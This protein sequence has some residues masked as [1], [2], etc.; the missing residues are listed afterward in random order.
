MTIE[1]TYTVISVDQETNN[2]VVEYAAIGYSSQT[3]NV[4]LP[5]LN[6]ETLDDVISMYSPYSEWS[7]PQAVTYAPE[8]GATGT[9][10]TSAVIALSTEIMRFDA[11]VTE[12]DP[13]FF[14]L[15]RGEATFQQWQN[16]VDEIKA[17]YPN[18]ET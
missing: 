11:Y 14:K 6:V 4:R 7:T 15:Q 8:I 2:M 3:V 1:Y 9:L 16:K 13:I 17:R 12:S 10:Q 18:P 5:I